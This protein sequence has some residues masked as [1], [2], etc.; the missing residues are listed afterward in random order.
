MTTPALTVELSHTDIERLVHTM[1][2]ALT[3]ITHTTI[4]THDIDRAIKIVKEKHR[5]LLI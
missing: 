3:D 2:Q 4:Y 1:V 5:N